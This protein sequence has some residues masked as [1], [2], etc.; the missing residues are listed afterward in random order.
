MEGG[1]HTGEMEIAGI[2][3]S[4]FQDIFSSA[5]PVTEDWNEVVRTVRPSFTPDM[6]LV[7]DREFIE[8]EV[9][10]AVFSLGSNKAHGPDGFHASFFQH[11]WKIV[12]REVTTMC[13]QV[14]NG[15]ASVEEINSTFIC[16]IPKIKSPRKVSDF[17]PISLCNVVY[18][19]ITKTIANRLK[20]VLGDLI[21][22]NQSAFVPGRLI[23]DNVLAAFEIMHSMRQK[24]IGKVGWMALKLDMSKAYDK[25]EWGFI[26]AMMSKLGFFG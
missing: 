17:R 24:T 14:L 20:L 15:G 9:K 3:E 8:E 13:L 1:W 21:E 19:V 18:K 26:E 12:G 16:L 22:E 4:Y 2:V 7:L 5:L 25:V 11:N 10:A 23:S 6:T